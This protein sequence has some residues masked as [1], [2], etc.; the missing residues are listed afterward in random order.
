MAEGEREPAAAR[1]TPD[2]AGGIGPRT[3]FLTAALIFLI[4]L[5]ML[6]TE[7]VTGRYVSQGIPPLPAVGFL[8]LI[9]LVNP[10]L[11]RISARA[12]LGRKEII[13]VYALLCIAIPLTAAYGVRA[14]LPH[15]TVPFYYA[16]ADNNFFAFLRFIPKWYAPE[17]S[18]MIRQCYEGA[19]NGLVPWRYWL[20]PLGLWLVFLLAA[21]LVVRALVGLLM[22]E[23]TERERLTFPLTYLP[24]EM[25][26][27]EKGEAFAGFFRNPLMWLGFGIAFLFNFLNVLRAFNPSVPSLP[28]YTDFGSLITERPWTALQPIIL[29][30]RPEV[31]GLAYLV[32]LDILFSTWFCYWLNRLSSFLGAAVGYERAG[33]PYT[34]EQATGAYI[35]MGLVLLW[36][37]R[38]RIAL[39]WRS[40]WR[41]HEAEGEPISPRWLFLSLAGGLAVMLGWCLVSGLRWWL[42]VVFLFVILLF[43]IV[44]GRIRAE[45]GAPIEFLYPYDYPKRILLYT[46]GTKRLMAL[47]KG[48]SLTVLSSLAWLSRH[49]IPEMTGAYTLDGWRLADRSLLSRRSLSHWMPA[50]LVVGFA[51]SF[52]AHLAGYYAWGEN[53]IEGASTE[54]DYRTRVALWEFESLAATFRSQAPPDLNRIVGTAFGFAVVT[55]LV[56]VRRAFLRFPVHPLG[57]IMSVAYGDNCPHWWPFFLTWGVKWVVMRVGGIRLYQQLVPTFLGLFLGHFFTAGILWT[58]FSLFID[59]QISHRY[60]FF[61]G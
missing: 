61:F 42:A 39:L 31:V 35:S 56:L 30:H 29:Y 19:D 10:V 47:D 5:W 48:R 40:A 55:A 8:I 24:L 53:V 33:Y 60:H 28:F 16:S 3:L 7:L 57:Y 22:T 36:V 38:R 54:A 14:F 51:A 49:H 17:Q 20:L 27:E 44:Y 11:R 23:W 43:V 34:Q 4:N 13:A 32:P 59:P 2:A 15:L 9:V 12:A 26:A 25:T 18:E 37:A 6:H 45:T 21:Y 58:T 46:I 41:G 52:W 50:A 1:Q